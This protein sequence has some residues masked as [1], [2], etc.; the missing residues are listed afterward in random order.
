MFIKLDGKK[1]FLKSPRGDVEMNVICEKYERMGGDGDWLRYVTSTIL[2]SN[3]DDINVG[4]KYTFIL[5]K[6][7]TPNMVLDE[8]ENYLTSL[9]L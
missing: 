9:A 8:R 3:I 4:K 1:Y 2:K 7:E 6:Y 5:E